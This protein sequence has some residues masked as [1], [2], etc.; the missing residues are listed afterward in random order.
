MDP[1]E[2]LQNSES[3]RS[4][5]EDE[6]ALTAPAEVCPCSL[7]KSLYLVLTHS[8]CVQEL[9]QQTFPIETVPI[10]SPVEPP[11]DFSNEPSLRSSPTPTLPQ[12]MPHSDDLEPSHIA[13][14]TLEETIQE[15]VA[16]PPDEAKLLGLES[17]EDEDGWGIEAEEEE[18]V[19]SGLT[20][21]EEFKPDEE[22]SRQEEQDLPIQET[23]LN[24][25]TLDES[26]PIENEDPYPDHI[27]SRRSSED[28]NPYSPSHSDTVMVEPMSS[29]NSSRGTQGERNMSSPEVIEKSDAWGFDLEE[30]GGGAEILEDVQPEEEQRSESEDQSTVQHENERPILHEESAVQHIADR[31]VV[32]EV[33]VETEN[34]ELAAT[35]TQAEEHTFSLPLDSLPEPT[36]EPSTWEESTSQAPLAQSP[37]IDTSQDVGSRSASPSPAAI[38]SPLPAADE[39]AVAD[40]PWDLDL[41]ESTL[42]QPVETPEISE[43]QPQPQPKV[44]SPTIDSPQSENVE[45]PPADSLDSSW[46]TLDVEEPVETAPSL[47]QESTES[48]QAEKP[49]AE[50]QVVEE[51]NQAEPT[52]VIEKE[53]EP[54]VELEQDKDEESPSTAKEDEGWGWDESVEQEATPEPDST[55]TREEDSL[56]A[57]L[58]AGAAAAVSAIAVG[59]AAALGFGTQDPTPSSPLLS[60]TEDPS[61]TSP[62]APEETPAPSLSQPESAA[63]TSRERSSSTASA[64]GW[65]WDGEDKDEQEETKETKNREVSDEPIPPPQAVAPVEPEPVDSTPLVRLEEMMVSKRSREIVKIAEEVLVEALTVA[66][67]S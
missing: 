37:T 6:S 26:T 41:E 52:Q 45:R 18:T 24:P 15:S 33:P 44:A 19:E 64:E 9:Q 11:I 23:L 65:G 48:P 60:T 43:V 28:N 66:S 31:P 59:T 21:Q 61:S 46:N 58:A 4:I 8:Y 1:V 29:S 12:P 47:Q 17:G 34:V 22:A 14:D 50:A 38:P 10:D 25:T 13:H 53:E 49:I 51:K 63:P 2:D 40:D 27:D 54:R 55:E 16:P 32:E 57:P 67:P 39:D 56:V 20:G 7:I 62:V 36:A 5:E 42:P 3:T 35:R 30:G